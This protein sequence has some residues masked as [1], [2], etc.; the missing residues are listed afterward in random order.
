[1]RRDRNI[2]FDADAAPVLKATYFEQKTAM[3]DDLIISGNAEI[4]ADQFIKA[5]QQHRFRDRE[6]AGK[7]A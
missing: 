1:M 5:V 2:A 7:I 3:K 6:V 4:P